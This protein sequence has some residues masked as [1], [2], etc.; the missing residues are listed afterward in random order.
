MEIANGDFTMEYTS[1]SKA[2]RKV[3][4]TSAFT[5]AI[6]DVE[7][8]LIDGSIGPFWITSS[9]LQMTAFTMPLCKSVY[10]HSMM[11]YLPLCAGGNQDML[12]LIPYHYQTMTE[13]SL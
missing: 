9:R 2:A 11:C 6:Q 1:G 10:E 12:L 8:G 13:P 5:A 4:P 3:H 7:D